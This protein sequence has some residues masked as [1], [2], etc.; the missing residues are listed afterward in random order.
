VFSADGWACTGD[1]GVFADPMYSPGADLIGFANC[2]ISWMVGQDMEGG[3]TP[4]MVEEKSR[5]IISLGELL[6]RSIQANYHL[7][8]SAQAMGAKAFWDF[9]AGWAVIQPLMFGKAFLESAD[10]T[11]VRAAGKTFFFLSLQMNQMFLDWAE[12]SRG[13]VGYEYI[14]YLAVDAIREMRERNL[15]P[16]KPLDELIRDQEQNMVLMEDL[17]QV[18]FRVAVAD[19]C[20]EDLPRLK[21]KWLN[22]WAITLDPDKWEERGL[23]SPKSEPRDL[24]YLA[25]P[26]FEMFN[27][28]PLEQAA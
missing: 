13:D 23:F 24:S 28:R 15:I 2:C 3:L 21:G 27:L 18:L 26:F 5:F 20:P 9:I 12:R 11:R 17:A 22:A 19:C 10:H 1:A 4:E 16:D 7:L 25:D 8:G 14:D 6:T